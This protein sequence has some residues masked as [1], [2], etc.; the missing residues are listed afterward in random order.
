MN[1]KP[2]RRHF[3]D[4][5]IEEERHVVVESEYNGLTVL[6]SAVFFGWGE[7]FDE[8]RSRLALLVTREHEADERGKLRRL[9]ADHIFGRRVADE[10]L[11]E[12]CQ[13]RI[14]RAD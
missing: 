3:A 5:G 2:A 13:A 10:V 1:A 14:A 9:I 11:E 6:E 4:A 12:R 8:R 7:G